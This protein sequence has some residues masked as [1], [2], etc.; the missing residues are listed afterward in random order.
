MVAESERAP[1]FEFGFEGGDFVDLIDAAKAHPLQAA[2][3]PVI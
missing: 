2:I 3:M 1:T